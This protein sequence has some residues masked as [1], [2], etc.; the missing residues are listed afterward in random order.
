MYGKHGH[1]PVDA[2]VLVSSS[3]FIEDALKL[4]EFYG[5]K[6]IT[7]GEATPEF[8]GQIVN[9]LSSVWTKV[10]RVT[11]NR[12]Q[13]WVQWP[14]GDTQVVDATD[15]IGIY[16]PDGSLICTGNDLLHTA[17]QHYNPNDLAFRDATGEEKFFGRVSR[18]V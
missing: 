17:M 10:A 13:L 1:L 12:M 7:P 11:P 4:A 6:A 15:E 16:R 5:I 9:N 18:L 2:T 3:G 14:E 8:I